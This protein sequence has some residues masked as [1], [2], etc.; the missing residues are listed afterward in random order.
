MGKLFN[1]ALKDLRMVFRDPG[2][3][4]MMLATPFMLTLVMAF[5]FG[6]G[7]GSN[8]LQHVSLVVVNH[9]EGTL[10]QSLVDTLH[11]QGLADLLSPTDLKD[12]AAARDMV[13]N[14]ETV[15]AVIIPSGFSESLTSSNGGAGTA[16]GGGSGQAVIELYTNPTKPVSAGV[17]R[18]VVESI[19]SRYTAGSVGG[20]VT[21]QQLI[22]SRLI[23]PQEALT[24]GQ[25]IGRRAALQ[26]TQAQLITV[27]SQ[28]ASGGSDSNSTVGFDWLGYMAPSMAIMFLMFTVTGGGRAILAEREAGTLPRMLVSPTGPGQVIGGKV[29]GIF[30]IGLV[31][32]GILIVASLLLF[33]LQWGPAL[34]VVLLTVALVAAATGWGML[35]A[36]YCRTPAQAGQFGSMLALVFAILAGNLVPRQVLPEWLRN[37]S[38]VTPNAWGLEGYTKL[39]AGS[40][41]ADIALIIVALLAMA[42]VLFAGATA[43]F[44]RQYA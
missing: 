8:L 44:R 12:D 27:N 32:M 30:V 17:V 38:Y 25:E 3:L 35:L 33:H 42:A 20:Q 29:L 24:V 2:T 40:G 28:N 41:L 7:G 34:G 18:S 15:A 5:A 9:D 26:T 10:G 43:L 11:S 14:R 6:G 39:A 16:Q 37:I 22:A 31:Q 13:D 19:V 1:I 21:M 23:S 4:I 36:A